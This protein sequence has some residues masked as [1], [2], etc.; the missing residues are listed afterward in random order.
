MLNF[1]GT[2]LLSSFAQTDPAELFDDYCADCHSIGEGDMKGPDL[3]GVE[4]K[5][6]EDW[7]IKF[8]R[9]AKTMISSGDKKAVDIWEK[10]NKSKMPDT[11]LSELEIKSLIQYIGNLNKN[12]V[13]V[14]TSTPSNENKSSVSNSTNQ[15]IENLN[16]K[17]DKYETELQNFEKKI[18]LIL[19]YHKKSFSA[20]ITDE[21][22]N[23]GKELFEGDRPF[24]NNVPVCVTC[25]NTFKIDSLN[26]NPSA[27]D[28][29]KVLSN[30]DN[31]EM[32]T[33]IINPS[34]NKMKEVLKDNKLT[35]DESFYITAFLQSIVKPGL[36]EHKKI[37]IKLILFIIVCILMFISFFDLIFTKIV[38]QKWLNITVCFVTAVFIGNTIIVNARN[39]GLS[40]GYTPIQPIKF[41][42]KIHVKENK[43]NCIFCHNSPEFS[44][45]SG[46]P[47]TNVCMNCHNKIKSGEMTGQFEINKIKKSFKNKKPIEW[48]KIHNLP[49]HVFFSHAQHVNV[50]KIEC[51]TCHGAIDEMDITSQH[52]SLSMGWCVKCHRESEVQFEN[53][54]YYSNHKELHNDLKLGKINNVTADKI[55]ANDCAKCH[56]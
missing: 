1:L 3:L 48:I 54:K 8:I 39:I 24:T 35:D 51:Q 31:M 53:N 4:R 14:I 12:K 42:H 38:K 33:I 7:L 22:I 25:H 45:E 52:A 11:N 40:K 32:S 29:A 18:D 15:K 13:E 19:E 44:I 27:H 28:I 2:G 43:I 6:N 55:G 26:W 37:P 46:I 49:D 36:K 50:G 9:S 17:I 20:R 41:S 16:S 56:Y 47:S 23:R 21:E 30:R 10:Y 34:S 5:Y